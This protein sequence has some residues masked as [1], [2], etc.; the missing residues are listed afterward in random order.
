M[1]IPI[2]ESLIEG[3]KSPTTVMVPFWQ[4]GEIAIGMIRLVYVN[5][6]KFLNGRT[7]NG[8]SRGIATNPGTER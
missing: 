2:R 4:P 5:K 7:S 6:L 8:R 1:R 3:G